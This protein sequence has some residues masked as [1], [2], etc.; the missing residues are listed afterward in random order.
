MDL[1]CAAATPFKLSSS[2]THGPQQSRVSVPE[3][4][5]FSPRSHVQVASACSNYFL[6]RSGF[7]Q[8]KFCKIRK[9]EG[10]ST[11]SERFNLSSCVANGIVF[12]SGQFHIAD[13]LLQ[14]FN[15][16]N[17]AN[18]LEMTKIHSYNLSAGKV[19]N[20]HQT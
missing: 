12:F 5:G 20:F 4:V 2:A 13:K 17:F 9:P 19:F 7:G 10:L 16:R 11:F 6:R 1:M 18:K 3:R 15:N 14:T 8:N